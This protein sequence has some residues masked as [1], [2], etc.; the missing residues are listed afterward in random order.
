MIF[1]QQKKQ[2]LNKLFIDQILI[3]KLILN[4]TIE[5]N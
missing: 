1:Q 4:D 3:K 5:H 2:R